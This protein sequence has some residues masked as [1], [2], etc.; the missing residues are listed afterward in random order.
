MLMSCLQFAPHQTDRT[1]RSHDLYPVT[2]NLVTTLFIAD[3][4]SSSIFM[5]LDSA[6]LMESHTKDNRH[7]L[8]TH[9]RDHAFVLIDMGHNAF[10]MTSAHR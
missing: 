7:C 3:F 6:L 5:P 4:A 8:Y 9:Y 1:S 2:Q 10:V